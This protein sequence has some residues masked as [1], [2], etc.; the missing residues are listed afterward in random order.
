MEVKPKTISHHNQKS[1]TMAQPEKSSF[2]PRAASVGQILF[3]SYSELVLSLFQK[4]VSIVTGFE[5]F[6]L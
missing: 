1:D 3:G 2:S 6:D 5:I 4:I